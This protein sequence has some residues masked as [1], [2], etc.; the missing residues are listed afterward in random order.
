M[1]R[2]ERTRTVQVMIAI[3]LL[4]TLILDLADLW[5]K[6]RTILLMLVGLL[7]AAQGVPGGPVSLELSKGS[8]IAYVAGGSMLIILGL[9]AILL[10]KV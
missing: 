1:D 10:N 8:R 7:V 5:P 6:V 2:E 9:V 4:C 3:L